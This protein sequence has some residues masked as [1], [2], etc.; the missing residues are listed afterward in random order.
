[1]RTLF[2][3]IL[4]AVAAVTAGVWYM[5]GRPVE[6]PQFRTLDIS[7]GE[8]LLAVSATERWNRSR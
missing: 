8:L 3:F 6:R 7:R 5:N 4:F 2:G 1:M